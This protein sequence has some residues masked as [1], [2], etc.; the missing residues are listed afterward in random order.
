M[1]TITVTTGVD[2]VDASDGELSLREAIIEA[3]S[4][5]SADQIVLDEAL[6]GMT[7]VL[8]RSLPTVTDG[9][10]IDSDSATDKLDL[11]RLGVEMDAVSLTSGR[12]EVDVTGNGAADFA[13]NFENNALLAPGDIL[14]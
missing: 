12:I 2:L 8:G 9:L 6:R 10:V 13:I 11:T 4:T 14:L 5:A 7:L 3:N 1:A